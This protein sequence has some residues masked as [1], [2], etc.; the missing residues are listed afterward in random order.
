[1]VLRARIDFTLRRADTGAALREHLSRTD[2][3]G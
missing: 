3:R 1:M 2:E